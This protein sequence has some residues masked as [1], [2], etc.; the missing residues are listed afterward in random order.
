MTVERGG[1]G[2]ITRGFRRGLR[3]LRIVSYLTIRT[4]KVNTSFGMS[5]CGGKRKSNPG[6]YYFADEQQKFFLSYDMLEQRDVS[7][8][9]EEV[10][11]EAANLGRRESVE[12]SRKVSGKQTG[13]GSTTES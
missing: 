2:D 1:I 13:G 3:N 5:I 6:L 7:L 11:P 12:S 8:P 10:H 4:N 9:Y